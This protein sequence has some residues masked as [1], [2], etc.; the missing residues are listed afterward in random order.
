MSEALIATLP[1]YDWAA[2]RPATD[3]LWSALSIALRSEG[4]DAP[5]SLNRSDRRE[6]LWRSPRLILGQ[7]CGFPYVSDL[8]DCVTLIGTPDYGEPNCPAGWYR[9]V[10][11]VRATDP[12]SDLETFRGATLAV[13]GRDSQSGTMAMMHSVARFAHDQ[14]FFD[15]VSESGS[16]SNSIDQVANGRADIAAIDSITWR[17]ATAHQSAAS[18]LRVLSRTAPTPGLPYVAARSFDA[19]SLASAVEKGLA[20][21]DPTTAASLSLR[22][23]VRTR[24]DD[25]DI[26]RQRAAAA[27]PVL[28]A[29]GLSAI[30]RGSLLEAHTLD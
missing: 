16:H 7:T 21:L 17:L 3:M 8:R 14:A 10:I 24:P 13:N 2:V 25:Y 5:E 9:S 15:A 6:T 1:M 22:G 11:V 4:Y 20:S 27:A 29:H 12:R 19:G 28:A 26:I 30:G 23:F 18:D